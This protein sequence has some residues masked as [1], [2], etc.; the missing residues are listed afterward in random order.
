MSKFPFWQISFAGSFSNGSLHQHQLSGTPVLWW[1]DLP[2]S[3]QI[4]CEQA[5]HGKDHQAQFQ[6]RG[7]PFEVNQDN[8]IVNVHLMTVL[9]TTHGVIRRL[10][11]TVRSDTE[12]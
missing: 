5:L 12:L 1:M 2:M 8:H 4:K 7:D 6:Y 10:R 3:W 9:N 11:R